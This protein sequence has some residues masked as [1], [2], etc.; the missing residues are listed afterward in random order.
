MKLNIVSDIGVRRKENQ[1][2]YWGSR[3]SINDE[4]LGIICV[5]DGMGGLSN[6]AKASRMA[7]EKVKSFFKSQVNIEILVEELKKVNKDIYDEGIRDGSKMGTTLTLVF[8]YNNRYSILQVGD[9][10]CYKVRG[11]EKQLLTTDH[12][13]IKKYNITKES[14]PSLYKKHSS[15]LTRC[16][17]VKPEVEID[18]YD[19][20]Y[21]NGDKF[22]VCSD[23]FW[24]FFENQS[25]VEDLND[26]KTQIG[27]CIA[28]G[29]T[30]N[31]TV[32]VLEV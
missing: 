1:D 9:S 22:L 2:N 11:T 24:H 30:D 7:I 18:I 20:T 19:G 8:C 32:G 23:G 26:L 5:C 21:K 15:S 31:I 14:N 17:G 29:E 3:L 28:N 6:G 4:E 10:R 16:L 27:K 13:V 25:V 12:S